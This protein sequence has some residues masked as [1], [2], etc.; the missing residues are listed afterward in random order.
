MAGYLKSLTIDGY[1]FAVPSDCEPKFHLGGVQI[2]DK[3]TFGN[4]KSRGVKGVV[5]GRIEGLQV[6]A[7]ELSALE[8]LLGR[9]ELPVRVETDDKS[10]TCDGMIVAESANVSGKTNITDNFDIVSNS[11]K[12]KHS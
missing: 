1:T 4:N 11:G 8:N 7:S 2:V 10:Y 5:P 6:D 9:E 3:I 12:L